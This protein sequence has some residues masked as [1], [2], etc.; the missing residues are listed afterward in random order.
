MKRRPNCP[1]KVRVVEK[2]SLIYCD[3]NETQN[4]GQ[5]RQKKQKRNLPA[6]RYSSHIDKY[7]RTKQVEFFLNTQRPESGDEVG[8]QIILQEKQVDRERVSNIQRLRLEIRHQAEKSDEYGRVIR[9]ERSQNALC[10][11]SQHERPVEVCGP[12]MQK[13]V[14]DKKTAQ[15]EEQV[16]AHPAIQK[17]NR[18]IPIPNFKQFSVL[19]VDWVY[20]VPNKY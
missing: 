11:I 7:K 8:T 19:F 1:E 6:K 17:R 4:R 16:H 12:T 10:L 5:E 15:H 18:N 2:L 13:M 20:R 3:C 9:R 14:R